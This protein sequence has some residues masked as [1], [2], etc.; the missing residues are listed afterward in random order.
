MY[1]LQHA[2]VFPLNF[3][4]LYIT[5]FVTFGTVR[6]HKLVDEDNEVT[7]GPLDVCCFQSNSN[8]MK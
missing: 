7:K 5:I 3:K 1:R 8:M 4:L 2:K 6:T